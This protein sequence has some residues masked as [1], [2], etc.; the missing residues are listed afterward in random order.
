[1][2][3][4]Q[5]VQFWLTLSARCALTEQPRVSS[6]PP[7][8]LGAVQRRHRR[9]HAPEVTDSHGGVRLP[10]PEGVLQGVRIQADGQHASGHA[11]EEHPV[12]VGN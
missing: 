11:R 9:S 1:M 6:K 3:R 7:A 2:R 12:G 4:A 8:E 5:N 10:L